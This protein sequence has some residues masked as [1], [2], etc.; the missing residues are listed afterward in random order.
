ML[1]RRFCVTISA[2]VKT[3]EMWNGL[4][5][6]RH[7]ESGRQGCLLAMPS[8]TSAPEAQEEEG[9]DNAAWL[10][11]LGVDR[12]CTLFCSDVTRAVFSWTDSG[13]IGW[14]LVCAVGL[15][16]VKGRKRTLTISP[17]RPK[18]Y[19]PTS[20]SRYFRDMCEYMPIQ[21]AIMIMLR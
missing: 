9:Q 1:G 4:P 16:G 17:T 5:K 20:M 18:D 2:D 8:G 6:L 3:K 21:R 12:H 14:F 13:R 10:S 7:M 11:H 15:L 19:R